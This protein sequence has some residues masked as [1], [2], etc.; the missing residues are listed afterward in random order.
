VDSGR[1][2]VALEPESEV[3]LEFRDIARRVAAKIAMR[4][5]DYSAK[6]PKIVIQNT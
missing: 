4:A 1:P 2:T 5:R 3:A 6:F